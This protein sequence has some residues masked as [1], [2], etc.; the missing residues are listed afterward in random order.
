MTQQNMKIN[1]SLDRLHNV[2]KEDSECLRIFVVPS[3]IIVFVL[4]LAVFININHIKLNSDIIM[5]KIDNQ[6]HNINNDIDINIINKI[7]KIYDIL[8]K[9]DISKDKNDISK[10]KNDIS[11]DKT[12]N[13][14]FLSNIIKPNDSKYKEFGYGYIKL[15]SDN[16]RDNTHSICWRITPV[17]IIKS[18][19]SL[20]ICQH[21]SNNNKNIILN[22][23]IHKYNGIYQSCI[24]NK[25]YDIIDMIY[26]TPCK[27]YVLATT[28]VVT[29][30]AIWSNLNSQIPVIINNS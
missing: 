4:S 22:L 3:L 29:N 6:A 15:K 23:G 19:N 9:P 12:F 1:N 7:E 18:I 24:T 30:G 16:D 26:E 28:D 17:G 25:E 5:S 13:L 10:D 20:S 11:K 27:Y 2:I 8:N 21:S 14:N